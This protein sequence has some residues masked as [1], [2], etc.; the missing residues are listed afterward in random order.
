MVAIGDGAPPNG[1]I[2]S[3]VV[4]AL[5]SLYEKSAMLAVTSAADCREGGREQIV[6][7]AAAYELK[8]QHPGQVCFLPNDPREQSAAFNMGVSNT[9]KNIVLN[10]ATGFVETKSGQPF[11]I[12]HQYDRR[13]PVASFLELRQ[14][15]GSFEA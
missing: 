7:T 14:P 13:P 3:G 5:R 1:G 11:A 12:V 9:I 4:G 2:T 6:L 10:N 8:A 15:L